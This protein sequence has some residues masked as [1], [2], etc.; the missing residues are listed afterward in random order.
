MTTDT[1]RLDWMETHV[2]HIELEKPE[3]SIVWIDDSGKIHKNYSYPQELPTSMIRDVVDA[4]MKDSQT[5]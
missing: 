3:Y 5:T 1:Q 4:A 2:I